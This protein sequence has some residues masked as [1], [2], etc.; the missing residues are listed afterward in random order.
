MKT[1]IYSILLLGLCFLAGCS[2]TENRISKNQALFDSY[3]VE[4][5]SL[6]R[7]GEVAVGFDPEQVRMAL[8]KPDRE[9]TVETEEGK[10]IVWQYLRSKPGLG[11]SLGVGSVIGGGSSMGTGVGVSS[12][13]GNKELEKSI[14]FDRETGKVS[15]IE[16]FDD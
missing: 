2:T 14:V 12:G 1:T 16:S 9:A 6:I 7:N 5:Q 4:T 10:Q 11:L 8:G 15:R 13:S 3:S